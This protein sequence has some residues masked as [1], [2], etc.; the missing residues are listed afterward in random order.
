MSDR[1][2]NSAEG[3]KTHSRTVL[4]KTRHGM[5]KEVVRIPMTQERRNRFK[6][7]TDGK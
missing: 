6:P 7:K 4:T 2:K 5:K 3:C 1:A